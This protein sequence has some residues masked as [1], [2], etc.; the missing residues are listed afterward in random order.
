MDIFHLHTYSI[1]LEL[2]EHLSKIKE[3]GFAFCNEELEMGVKAVAAPIRNIHG[4]VIASIT[5]V[6]LSNRI[7]SNNIGKLIKIMLT[8]TRQLSKMLGYKENNIILGSTK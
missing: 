2:E 5:V 7:H 4:K 3:N 6:G 8:S 1:I